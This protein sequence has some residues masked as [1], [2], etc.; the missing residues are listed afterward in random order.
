LVNL[1]S[2]G[3]KAS[4]QVP[5]IAVRN[6]LQLDGTRIIKGSQTVPIPLADAGAEAAH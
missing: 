3:K 5:V 4:D 1:T 6:R 2:S